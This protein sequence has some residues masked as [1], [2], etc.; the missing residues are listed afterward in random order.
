M[1]DNDFMIATQCI[2]AVTTATSTSS[3]ENILME[4]IETGYR[5]K[6]IC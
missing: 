1:S 4:T 2:E 6:F 3:S 5:G